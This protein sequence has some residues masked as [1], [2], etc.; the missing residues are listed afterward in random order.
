MEQGWLSL[1]PP[2][3]TICAAIWSKKILP[4]LLLGLLVGGYLLNP[5]LI[6]G[7]ETAIT[8][9]IAILSDQGNL[10]VLLFLYLFSGLIALVRKAGG[11]EA[12]SDFVGGYIKS[13]RGVLLTLWALIP[14]TFI[15]CGFRIVGSGSILRSLADRN[16]I[17]KERIAFMLN[18]TAS[19]IVELIPIATTFIGFNIANI[20]IGLK[21][22]GVSDKHSAYG[23]LL[24]AI[25]FEFFSIV[26][27][28]I[29]FG[30]IFFE[31]KGHP[32]KTDVRQIDRSES[33]S[34]M[35]MNQMSAEDMEIKPRIVNLLIPLLTVVFL[36]VFFFWYFGKENGGTTI[37]SAIAATNPNKAMLVALFVSVCVTGILYFFQ[38]YPVKKMSEDIIEGGNELMGILAILIVAWAL[39]ATSQELNLSAFIQHQLGD[40]LPGWSIPIS[41]F[42]LSSAV[43]YFIGA[44]WAAASLIMPFALSLAVTTGAGIPICAAAV[45]TGGTFGDTTSPVA[46][47]TNMASNMAGADHMSYLKYAS[48]YNFVALA[49]AAFLFLIFG[50]IG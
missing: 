13:P 46:G 38:K 2:A 3:V 40:S 31:W 16:K 8:H 18:N 48:R 4:S 44:G 33:H 37:A 1:L 36:S 28:A 6:G 7:F 27:L 23:V 12:F 45:I 24:Q 50:I 43:T 17:A 19:P 5:T 29:T 47:M 35:K 21:A 32:L 49:V 34:M 39:G 22:A 25:P 9:L 41:L 11:I 30:S 10:Q 15:D 42:L 14:V 20:A 26:V